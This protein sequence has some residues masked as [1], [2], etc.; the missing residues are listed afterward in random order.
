MKWSCALPLVLLLLPGLVRSQTPEADG[1]ATQ[2][3]DVFSEANVAASRGALGEAKSNYLELMRAGVVDPD[4]Y[5]NLATVLAQSSDYPGAILNYE[6][7]LSLRPGD[8]RAA[9]NL[10]AAEK[11]LEES[12]AEA[13]GEAS[14]KRNSSLGDAVYRRF[15]E[16][17]L[18]YA[19]LVSNLLLFAVLAWAWVRRRRGRAFY[20]LF[21]SAALVLLFSAFGLA[22]KSDWFREGPMAV[23]L[24]DRVT[25]LEGPDPRAQVRGEARGADRGVLTDQDGDFV[26]LRVIGG[27]EGWVEAKLVGSITPG[28]SAH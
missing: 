3:Q 18:A 20:S 1:P 14:I 16:S 28:H 21:I 22:T 7:S 26:K 5:F 11:T 27:P 8:A 4:V 23:V 13:E 9:E 10:A 19:L 25:L 2:L 15:P 12:R 6:R 24:A 17:S